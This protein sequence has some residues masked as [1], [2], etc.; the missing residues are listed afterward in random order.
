LFLVAQRSTTGQGLLD[1]RIENGRLLASPSVPHRTEQFAR[2]FHLTSAWCARMEDND[3]YFK[4]DFIEKKIIT[5]VVTQGHIRKAKIEAYVDTNWE[6]VYK[7]NDKDVSK[8]KQYFHYKYDNN[9]IYV[10]S[11]CALI[12]KKCPPLP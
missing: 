9:V 5:G 6:T 7:N 11:K 4:V 2:L 1:G 10:H 3:K 12:Q 8:V